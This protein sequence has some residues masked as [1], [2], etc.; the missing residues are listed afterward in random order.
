MGFVSSFSRSARREAGLLR[1]RPWDL[2]LISW[3]PLLACALVWWIFSAGLPTRLPIGLV[4][5]DHSTLSRQAERF[6]N[7]TPGLQVRQRYNNTAQAEGG[8][9]R[10]DVYAV[11]VIPRD[12]ARDIKQGRAVH[13]TLLHNAQLGT[14]SGL[15]QRDVRSA[16]GTLSAGIE[17]AARTKRGESRQGARVSM[18]P[19]RTGMVTLFNTSLNYEQFLG[20]ALIPALLHIMAMT[21]GAWAVGRELRDGTLWQWL[22]VQPRWD[23]TL[24]ALLGKL[25]WSWLALAAV[26][27]AALLW[28]TWGRGWHP[29]GSLAWVALAQ[30][31]LL[32][33]S[34]AMGAAAAAATASLRTALSATGFITAPAFAFSGVGFPLVAMPPLARAW[35]NA[36]PY[37]HYIR[38]QIEQLQM[39]AP[40]RY[41]LPTLSVMLLASALL[42]ALCV[43]FL[44]K[45]CRHPNRWG[46]R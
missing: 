21:A 24:A 34:L 11:V 20:A 9:R 27:L 46:K 18:E 31:V 44:Q 5:N 19:I 10:T 41:S 1:E 15:I 7:A 8:L 35:A 43:P 6:L 14:H 32:A 25:L 22:G 12:F 36:L 3:V 38:L 13:L 33:L 2:A 40:L 39:A 23:H 45:S 29:P 26:G 28:I 30:T 17:I 42:L 16:M 4:D 37:T